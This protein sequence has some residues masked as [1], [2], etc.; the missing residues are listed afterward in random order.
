MFV[1]VTCICSSSFVNI[2]LFRDFLSSFLAVQ[3]DMLR[4]MRTALVA[5]L[6]AMIFPFVN[7]VHIPSISRVCELCDV[8]KCHFSYFTVNNLLCFDYCRRIVRVFKNSHIFNLFYDCF[9]LRWI[10]LSIL[11]M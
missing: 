8:V 1:V 4:S 9:E 11:S 5:I 3:T 6:I 2:N 7:N 10:R